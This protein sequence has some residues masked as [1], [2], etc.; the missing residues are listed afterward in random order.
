LGAVAIDLPLTG[1]SATYATGNVSAA[2]DVTIALTGQSATYATGTLAAS[3]SLAL[4]GTSSTA[5][6]GT[7]SPALS[8]GLTGSSATGTAGTI[9]TPQIDLPINGSSATYATGNVQA[10]GQDVTIALTGISLT[11]AQGTITAPSAS[12]SSGGYF[13]G[14]KKRHLDYL[15][16]PT[17]EEIQRERERLGI[18][19]PS[20]Q[21][22][23]ERV[24]V[25]KAATPE[26][27]EAAIAFAERLTADA[28]GIKK[29]IRAA[30]PERRATVP[31]DA[32]YI[33]QSLIL[34]KLRKRFE[35]DRAEEAEL[36]EIL[37]L[38][39]NME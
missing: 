11:Y 35:A 8:A 16:S 15:P 6:A 37:T 22:A 29:A 5:S 2:G 17:A 31:A 7:V 3:I 18:L 32:V 25:Q 14:G 23:V 19:P 38:W 36:Q 39:L 1:Q 10:P 4:T 27:Y 20:V 21:K 13:H 30:I 28:L 26:T 12:G 33:A 34:D 9:G 24:V